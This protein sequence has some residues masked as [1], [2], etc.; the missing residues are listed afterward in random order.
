[1]ALPAGLGLPANIGTPILAAVSGAVQSVEWHAQNGQL[2]EI[3]HG[4]GLVTRRA[5]VCRSLVQPGDIVRRAQVIAP[6]G[7]IGHATG[8][9][10]HFAVR[11]AGGPHDPER[12]RAGGAQLPT[13]ARSKARRQAAAA[14][15]AR[16]G[17]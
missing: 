6:V 4:N 5:H 2:I 9:H 3:N 17:C 12:L 10:L 1:M 8:A 7:D 16:C 13:L 15:S 11:V 14:R